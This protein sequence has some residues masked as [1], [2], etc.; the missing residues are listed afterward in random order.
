MRTRTRVALAIA[1]GPKTRPDLCA[2]LARR[3]LVATD[4]LQEGIAA[5]LYAPLDTSGATP[6][7]DRARRT[8]PCVPALSAPRAAYAARW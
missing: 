4:D 8:V 2:L 3:T 6:A 1:Y 5:D 7:D